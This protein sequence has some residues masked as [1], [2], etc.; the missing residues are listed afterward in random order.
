MNTQ[1]FS[2]WSCHFDRPCLALT[3]DLVIPGWSAQTFICH[4]LIL[5]EIHTTCKRSVRD[6]KKEICVCKC[7]FGKSVATHVNQTPEL[8][9]PQFIPLF[10]K[11]LSW[12]SVGCA[13][14]SSLGSTVTP[15]ETWCSDECQRR[16]NMEPF[17]RGRPWSS[18]KKNK[19]PSPPIDRNGKWILKEFE[20]DQEN[21]R[22]SQDDRRLRGNFGGRETSWSGG[23][24]GGVGLS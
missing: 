11:R 8:F 4:R 22:T 16:R 9:S 23:V 7:N 14:S 3:L 1:R 19:Q 21:R 2:R 5:P 17:H 24:G 20:A 6:W 13:S 18:E 12:I 15:T 10:N